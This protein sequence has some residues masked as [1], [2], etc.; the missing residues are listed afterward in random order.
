MDSHNK[1]K[2]KHK[3]N[4]HFTQYVKS[5]FETNMYAKTKF[6]KICI[7]IILIYVCMYIY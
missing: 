3:R 5:E 4:I 1:Q 7:N 6:K 2:R